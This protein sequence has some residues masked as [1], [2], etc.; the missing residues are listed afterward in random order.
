MWIF[1]SIRGICLLALLILGII[2]SFKRNVVKWKYVFGILGVLIVSHLLYDKTHDSVLKQESEKMEMEWQKKCSTIEN[3]RE[4][5]ENTTWTFTKPI[6]EDD[7]FNHWCR[8]VFKNGKLYYYE[9]SPSKGEWGEP[10][11]C[12]Y[13]IEE[14]RYSN[15]G[16]KYIAV[17]WTSL[18][19]YAFVPS[20]R[21]IS[22]QTSSGYVFGAYLVEEDV[23]PW[24]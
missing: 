17:F 19:K 8:L 24:D 7:K 5:I 9:V 22:F 11:I 13:T 10:N 18:I 6:R 15:T 3:V 14:R 1:E 2:A 23:F 16:K 4:L 21:S 20:E 12:D